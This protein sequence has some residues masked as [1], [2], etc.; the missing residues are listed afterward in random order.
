MV[1]SLNIAGIKSAFLLLRR[2]Q[3]L[4]PHM[5]VSDIRSIPF[6][7]MRQNGIKYLVFDKDNCLTAPY[8]DHIHPDFQ[9]AWQKCKDVFPHNRILIAS[10]SAGTPDDANCK[11]AKSVELALGVPVLRHQVKK[12]A[13]GLEIMAQLGATDPREVAMIGD[14]LATDIVLAN[15]NGFLGVW[16]QV[17]ITTKGDNAA[18]A[19]LRRME[20]ALY[21]ILHRYGFEAPS[22]PLNK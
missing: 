16:T 19:V 9:S 22:H 13:C 8:A 3:L 15:I 6:D 2:P 17:I 1:Q 7:E 5:A 10:N 14:R 20:H 4:L 21:D 12:P 18:A 11:A